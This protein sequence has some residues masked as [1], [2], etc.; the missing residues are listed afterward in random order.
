M[1]P[2]NLQPIPLRAI[3]INQLSLQLKKGKLDTI[4]GIPLHKKLVKSLILKELN[5]NNLR[6]NLKNKGM[7]NHC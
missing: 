3:V 5:M 6:V 7:L 1:K 4:R 2:T